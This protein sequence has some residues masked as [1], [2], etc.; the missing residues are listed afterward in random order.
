MLQ[1]NRILGALLIRMSYSIS[2]FYKFVTISNCHELK[3]TLKDLGEKLKVFGTILVAPEG[4]NGTI[5]AEANTLETFIHILKSDKRFS[6]LHSK[7][8]QHETIPFKRWKVKV[9]REILKFDAPEA[10]PTRRVGIY[11][12]PK[13]WN[14]LIS[15]PD[16][17]LIDTRN[18]YEIAIGNFPDAIDPQTSNFTEF[19]K[20]V[21]SE[22]KNA[23][24][25]KI[26]MYCTGGIR[27]EKASAY[28]LSLGFEEVYHLEG[29]ILKYLEEINPKDS[30]WNGACFVFDERVSVGHGLHTAG[31]KLCHCGF[32][33]SVQES[34][35]QYCKKQERKQYE[36]NIENSVMS[37]E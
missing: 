34:I 19:K 11:V 4:V 20:Y 7:V 31:H 5:A 22:L 15:S 28:L 21:C 3:D 29:G 27:C 12:K 10:D 2:A 1:A 26:A 16:I 30:L 32:P 24:H 25:R 14:A 36:L 37:I 8:S 17:T 23:E 6:D 33:I 35:C 13:D 9:K 18:S